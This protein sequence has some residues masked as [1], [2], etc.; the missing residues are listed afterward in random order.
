ML[1]L[2]DGDVG[3]AS[4]LGEVFFRGGHQPCCQLRIH[5]P[6][7]V[8]PFAQ[9]YYRF[10]LSSTELLDLGCFQTCSLAVPAPGFKRSVLEEGLESTDV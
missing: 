5:V 6:L 9:G 4:L 2:F 8:C 7:L 1:P 3:F 10:S